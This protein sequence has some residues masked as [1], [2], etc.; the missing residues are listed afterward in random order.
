[1]TRI[2]ESELNRMRELARPLQYEPDS[3][4]VERVRAGVARRL[5]AEPALYTILASWFRPVAAVLAILLMILTVVL[6]QTGPSITTDLLAQ[7]PPIAAEDLY[8]D[9]Q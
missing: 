7:G 2:D 5:A 8:R 4:M 3:A 9:P 1:M 6:S